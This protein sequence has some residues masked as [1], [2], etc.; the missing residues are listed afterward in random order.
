MNRA[1]A[2]ISMVMSPLYFLMLSIYA[3]IHGFTRARIGRCSFWRSKEFLELCTRSMEELRLL[4]PELFAAITT[5]ES[6]NFY[7][8][9]RPTEQV[10]ILRSL[11]INKYFCDW[12]TKGVLARVVYA[13]FVSQ[14]FGGRA[15][16]KRERPL[17][18]ALHD[19]AVA[20]TYAWLN[21]H[22]FPPEL[23]EIHNK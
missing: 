3:R 5:G 10:D 6:F 20:K 15:F 13:Y 23:V 12:D 4:D 2:F 19:Q 21:E 18:Q 16:L 22:S 8:S 17:V 7:S 14:T 9:H 1:I 11:S